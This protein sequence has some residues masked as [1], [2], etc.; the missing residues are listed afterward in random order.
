MYKVIA[1]TTVT[2]SGLHVPESSPVHTCSLS[3]SPNSHLLS[4]IK[5]P[6]KARCTQSMIVWSTVHYPELCLILSITSMYVLTFR[7][8]DDT[9]AILPC[10]S[11][12]FLDTS[13][14]SKPARTQTVS[15]QLSSLELVSVFYTHLPLLV[16]ISLSI[17]SQ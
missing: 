15:I 17:L 12:T 13:S 6:S 1:V 11:L 10:C 4:P 9:P 2:S 5:S 14:T 16:S 8:P 7:S 3:P